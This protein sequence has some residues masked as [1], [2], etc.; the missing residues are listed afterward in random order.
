M[1]SNAVNIS[2][3][4]NHVSLSGLVSCLLMHMLLQMEFVVQFL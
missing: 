3:R 2:S 4:I 1:V